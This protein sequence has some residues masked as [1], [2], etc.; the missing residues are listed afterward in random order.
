MQRTRYR[1]EVVSG[2]RDLADAIERGE[3]EAGVAVVITGEMG[4]M[5]VVHVMAADTPTAIAQCAVG[6]HI[7]LNTIMP[8]GNTTTEG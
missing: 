1:P 5:A 4:E 3:V 2:L 8:Y 7:L 6:Q